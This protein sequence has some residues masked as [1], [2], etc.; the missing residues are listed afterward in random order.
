MTQARN[1]VQLKINVARHRE[2]IDRTFWVNFQL[3]ALLNG[4]RVVLILINLGFTSFRLLVIFIKK[5]H[6]FD[7]C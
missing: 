4:A 6:R 1:T 3:I 5:F 7:F 2:Q